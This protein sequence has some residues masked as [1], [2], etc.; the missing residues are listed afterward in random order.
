MN[1]ESPDDEFPTYTGNADNTVEVRTDSDTHIGVEKKSGGWLE[2]ETERILRFAGMKTQRERK[3]VFEESTNEH[4]RVDILAQYDNLTLFVECKDYSELKV[5]EKILFTLI[6]QVHDYRIDHPDETVVGVL[7][8]SAKNVGQNMGIQNKLQREGCQLWDG[9][10]IQKLQEKMI[11]VDSKSEFA[12]YLF[13]KLGYVLQSDDVD[14]DTLM[15]GQHRF[16]CRMH[17][18]SIPA[19]K[20][21]GN[22]FSHKSI[23]NDL[24][25]VLDG[26]GISIS[27]FSYKNFNSSEGE[28]INLYVDFQKTL[29]EEK[30]KEYWK[31]KSGLFRKPKESP[32]ELMEIGFESA[33]IGAITKTYGVEYSHPT[34][35]Y[36]IRSIATR[37]Q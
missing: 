24:K 21:I 1:S 13:E 4:Y 18:F 34:G 8:T 27:S 20:Y 35:A 28:R 22:K 36:Q 14:N 17:F 5:T 6:G 7:V 29:T 37:S 16:H 33:C 2:S 19:V 26:T 31:S 9:T 32:M 23:I 12:S 25:R 15:P 11:D 10:T 3:I 30:L